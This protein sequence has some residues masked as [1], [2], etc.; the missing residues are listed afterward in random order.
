LRES[1]HM[2]HVMTQ[3][4]QEAKISLFRKSS[5]MNSEFEHQR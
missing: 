4:T 5:L 2:V 1:K 3:F